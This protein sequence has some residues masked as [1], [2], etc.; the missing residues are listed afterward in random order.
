M[1]IQLTFEQLLVHEVIV[2]RVRGNLGDLTVLELNEAISLALASLKKAQTPPYPTINLPVGPPC[3]QLT[4]L[5]LD[6]FSLVILPN[7]EKNFRRGSSAKPCGTW[8]R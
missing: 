5:L 6:N 8:P 3:T 7:C 4:F 2:H 1:T